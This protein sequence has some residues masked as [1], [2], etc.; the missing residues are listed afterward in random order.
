MPCGVCLV[1]PACPSSPPLAP[2]HR[3]TSW[4][5]HLDER[6]AEG[7]VRYCRH[8]EQLSLV[9][10]QEGHQDIDDE[11]GKGQLQT[12]EPGFVPQQQEAP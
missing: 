8:R 11:A 6:E 3:D 1:T 10:E 5:A 4:L 9:A 7:E 12:L 2:A